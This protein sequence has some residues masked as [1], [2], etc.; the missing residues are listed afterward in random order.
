MPACV[1]GTLEVQ[2]DGE[3]PGRIL[4]RGLAAGARDEDVDTPELLDRG[5][6]RL[7]HR[8][9]VGDVG[10]HEGGTAARIVDGGDDVAATGLV[11]VGHDHASAFLRHGLGGGPS[12]PRRTAEDECR[13][14]LELH[15]C[16]P[17]SPDS[18]SMAPSS[19]SM[20]AFTGTAMPCAAPR[21]TTSPVRYWC[22][23]GRPAM[24]S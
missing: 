20:V 18:L 11:D 22:S 5:P 19:A 14:V 9:L 15:P 23:I 12:Q 24:R 13:L 8:R 10:R 1:V 6:H 4:V 17:V 16:L 21:R 3:L 7:L 2:V